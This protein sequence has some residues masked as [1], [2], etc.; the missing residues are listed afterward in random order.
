M[1]LQIDTTNKILIIEERVNLGEFFILLNNLF[2]DFKWEEFNLEMKPIPNWYNPLTVPLGPGYV[3]QY[4]WAGVMDGGNGWR[5]NTITMQN[6]QINP[7]PTIT[8][9]KIG[10]IPNTSSTNVYCVEIE[11]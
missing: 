6:M 5:G 8:T 2:P 11:K 10:S 1:K 7:S 9:E 3:G 4:P